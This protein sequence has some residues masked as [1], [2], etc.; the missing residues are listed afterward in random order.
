MIF[1]SIDKVKYTV[2]DA[3]KEQDDAIAEMK[4]K[5]DVLKSAI[6]IVAKTQRQLLIKNEETGS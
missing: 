1:S 6:E 4:K 3:I 5:M 2:E